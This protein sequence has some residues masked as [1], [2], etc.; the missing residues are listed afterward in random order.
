MVLRSISLFLEVSGLADGLVMELGEWHRRP[1]DVVGIKEEVQGLMRVFLCWGGGIMLAKQWETST[2][3]RAAGDV[4]ETTLYR[5]SSMDRHSN[6][7]PP[8]RPA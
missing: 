1:Q 8:V 6:S 3:I 2:G 4:Q 5:P 7:H